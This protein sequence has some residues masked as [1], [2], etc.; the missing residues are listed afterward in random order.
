MPGMTVE[1]RFVPTHTGESEIA[2]AEHCGLGH[3]R[4]RGKVRVVP[5][6]EFDAA[7]QKLAE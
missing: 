4:M 7:V 6:A 3:Y 1:T 5:A 2:C